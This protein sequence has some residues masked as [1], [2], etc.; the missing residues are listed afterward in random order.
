[1]V[2]EDEVTVSA[3]GRLMGATPL[4]SAAIAQV[5]VAK[6]LAGNAISRVAQFF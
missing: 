1:M 5:D 4:G 6:R 3:D 2:V